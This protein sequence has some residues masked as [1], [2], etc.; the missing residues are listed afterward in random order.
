MKRQ[1]SPCIDICE[2]SVQK[3]GALDA[4]GLEVNV[5]NGKH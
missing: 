2:F 5:E 4:E 1:K 3:V